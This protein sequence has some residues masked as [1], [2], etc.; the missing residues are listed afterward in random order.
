MVSLSRSDQDIVALIYV[1]NCSSGNTAVY[2]IV[3]SQK[4][5]VYNNVVNHQLRRE[6]RVSI[7]PYRPGKHIEARP[8]CNKCSHV[9]MVRIPY[10]CYNCVKQNNVVSNGRRRVRR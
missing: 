2:I 9:R 6:I 5:P 3:S 8:R 10:V 4:N 7:Q 1:Y